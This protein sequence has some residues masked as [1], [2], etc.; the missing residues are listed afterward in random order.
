AVY[1]NGATD[2]DT[3]FN[4]L[5]ATGTNGL[6]V[7]NS[8]GRF[9]VTG[10]GATPG[11][12]GTLNTT[13]SAVRLNVAE[14]VH[15]NFMNIASPTEGIAALNTDNLVVNQSTFTSNTNGWIGINVQ[16]DTDGNTGSPVI[17]TN[18]I[19]TGGGD[20]QTGILVVNDQSP[21]GSLRIDNHNINIP[22]VNGVG[23]DIRALDMTVPSGPGDIVLL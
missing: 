16:N 1:I 20:N 6:L 8:A 12:G 22:G 5:S 10:D 4:S 17:L 7:V 3:V 21:Q 11:S 2:I 9:L 14:N 13:G 18:N 23:I 19:I 15:L